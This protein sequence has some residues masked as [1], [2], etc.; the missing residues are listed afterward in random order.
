M[1]PPSQ[2]KVPFSAK[3]KKEQLK[4]KRERKKNEVRDEFGIYYIVSGINS[5]DFLIIYYD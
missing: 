1:P 4:S 3:Q 5:D 2:R